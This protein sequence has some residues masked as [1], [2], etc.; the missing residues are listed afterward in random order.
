MIETLLKLGLSDKEAKVYLA[1][2]E[3]GED[4]VQNISEKSGVNRATTYVI[5][6]KL[7]QLGLA[8]TVE[9]GKK[10]VF[11][12]ENPTE[13]VNILEEQKREIEVKK[14][15]LDEA[16]TGLQAIY[17]HSKS[18]PA[19][20]YFEGADGLEA[21]DRYGHGQFTPGTEYLGMIPIDTVESQFPVR[22]SKAVSERVKLGIKSRVIYTNKEE[23]PDFTNEKELREAVYLPRE[24]FPINASI[25]LYP[26]WGIKFF[27]YDVTNYFGVLIE[28]P[29]LAKNMKYL[30]ELAW[31]GAKHREELRK[32][33]S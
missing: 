1:T 18:K 9:R 25:T 5:L 31:E 15:N 28:S 4:T 33:N 3:L 29:I 13:L 17:N 21:L 10:T 27:N 11:I 32:S 30:F 19:V 26:D 6:E 12:A 2:L 7:M 20:R 16:M 23:K 8:S 24:E 14:N 22:R